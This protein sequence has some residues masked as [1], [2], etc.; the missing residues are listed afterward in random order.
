MARLEF[1]VIHFT[2]IEHSHHNKTN[3]VSISAH[4]VILDG[5]VDSR[6]QLLYT[7]VVLSTIF[8]IIVAATPET[9]A[10]NKT[11]AIGED[12]AFWAVLPVLPAPELTA[13]AQQYENLGF[14][15][16]FATQ[17]YGPPFVPLAAA[18]TVTSQLQLGTGIAITAARSPME[19]AMAIMDLDRISE[20]RAVLGLGTSISSW[21]SGVFGSPDIKPLTHLRDTIAAI[22]HIEAGA[23]KGL[24]PF[25]GIYFKAGFEA[26]LQTPPPYR[27]KVPIWVAALRE[28][29]V[30]LAA[31][32]ADGVIGHPMW[33]VDWTV[34]HM[35]PAFLDELQ[36]QGRDRK[37]VCV[38][39]WP[40][41][42]INDD[43][44]QA[45]E[46]ARSTVAY[47]ASAAQYES[48][49]EMNGFGE[50]ARAC[51]AGIEADKNIS[52]FYHHVPDEMVEAFV[53]TGS[54]E[55]VAEHLEPLWSVAD[56]LCPAPPM[57][58][59]PP[60]TVQLYMEKIGAFVAGQNGA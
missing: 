39:I 6:I 52:S 9:T 13:L 50:Q 1:I 54:I 11:N 28:K 60:E 48:F 47:Y 22:R 31:E 57:W 24:E 23:H 10:M 38:S 35:A 18:S 42:A 14:E 41:V 34:N 53:A 17:V 56:N 26:M 40:W 5:T 51:Q 20:G 2:V 37:D 36:K 3:T 30:R 19:T 16:V 15:G 29:L 46:D 33:S 43:K 21:T 4:H 8:R 49:W 45:I 25:D 58:N 12:R 44:V 55:E 7:Q 27:E 59:L 32:I